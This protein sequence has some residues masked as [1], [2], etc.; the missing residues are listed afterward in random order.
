[1]SKPFELN[2]PTPEDERD[3]AQNVINILMDA[4]LATSYPLPRI[5]ATIED[6]I[7][8]AEYAQ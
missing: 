7:N 5:N 2:R 8:L 1:M 6:A 4:D 3:S